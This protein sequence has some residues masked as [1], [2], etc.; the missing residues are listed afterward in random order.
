MPGIPPTLRTH[1]STVHDLRRKAV[2]LG[3]TSE[4]L[5]NTRNR[6]IEGKELSD[7]VR[8]ELELK[9]IFFF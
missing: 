1:W 3:A 7:L 8:N 6:K 9:P 5:N 2:F 4:N